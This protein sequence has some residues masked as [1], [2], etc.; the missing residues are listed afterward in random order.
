M[1]QF[2]KV[3]YEAPTTEVWEINLKNCML[4]V[5]EATRSAY[6]TAETQ[7]WE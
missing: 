6:G 4:Q 7:E 3:K 5:S 1:K 2:V